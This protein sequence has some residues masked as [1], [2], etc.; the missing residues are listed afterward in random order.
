[1]DE[2]GWL[3][4]KHRLSEAIRRRGENISAYELESVAEKHPDVVESAAF[5]IPGLFVTLGVAMAILAGGAL[6]LALWSPR[7]QPANI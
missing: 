3:Y 4:F 6:A 1:M 2:D 5:G 7:V